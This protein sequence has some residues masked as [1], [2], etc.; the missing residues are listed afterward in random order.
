MNFTYKES[1]V[2]IGKKDIFV[3]GI[4]RRI[5]RL[6]RGK[7]FNIPWGFAGLY[8]YNKDLLICGACDSVGTKIRIAEL[9]NI[10]NTIGIDVVAMNVN[11]LIVHNIKP[12]FFLD[13]ISFNKLEE[14]KGQ[15]ILEG[16]IE[17]CK[18]AGIVLLGGETA[19]MPSFF[20][21]NSFEVVGTAIG[22]TTRNKVIYGKLIKEG[23]IVIGFESSGVHSNGFSLIRKVIFK[24]GE[25]KDILTGTK[26][27]GKSLGDILLI[28][29]KIY[30]KMF[31]KVMGRFEANYVI[32]GAAHITGGGIEGNLCRIIPDRL[33][34]VIDTRVWRKPPIF[35]Y[36]Q[37]Q[38]KIS[39]AEMYKVFNMGIGFIM[40][41]NKEYFSRVYDFLRGNIDGKFYVIGEIEKGKSKVKMI[42]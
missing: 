35:E 15:Q 30:V 22:I 19:I 39:I 18:K 7:L 1:G 12:L 27:E 2:D 37:K 16:I 17:G 11:D 10:Y 33:C 41:I 4:L 38:G 24:N 21:K 26:I 29:T 36:I 9:L 23:D 42:F 3:E 5:R 31:L 34:A 6:S 13:Y 40:V 14:G 20:S 28:P 8:K 25:Y 32:R